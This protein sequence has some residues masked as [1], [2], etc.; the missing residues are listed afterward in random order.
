MD[1]R[2]APLA[3][4]LDLNTDLLLN[5]L[6][7]LTN[8]ESQYRLEGGGNSI[9]FLAAH[10]TDTR[11][12]LVSR[13]GHPLANP[14]ARYLADAKSIDEIRSWATLDQVRSAW[15]SVSLHLQATLESL[16]PDELARSDVHRFPFPDTTA[17]GLVGFLTQH[18][19]YHLGQAA[20]IRRQLGKPAM[21]YARGAKD[22]RPAGAA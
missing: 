21:S 5:T 19:S 14:L 22:R 4:I 16:R 18:D 12:F 8:S 7:G 1:A 15:M 17:L 2:L 6:E 13:L 3:L 20:F 10:L 9:A 11:H